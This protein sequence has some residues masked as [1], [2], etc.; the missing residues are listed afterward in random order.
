MKRVLVFGSVLLAAV[1]GLLTE[2]PA[3]TITSSL[4]NTAS[5]FSDGN[6]PA[7]FLVGGAQ[8]GQPA[9]FNQSYGNDE[10]GPNFSET[11][12]HSFGA[13]ADPILSASITIGIYEHDSAA[14]GSQLSL[15]SVDS[16]DL[17]AEL[18][19]MFEALG[20]GEDGEYNEY[21]LAL[22]G[23]AFAAL[24]DGSALVSLTL[25]GPGLVTP[26]FP[27]PGPNPPEERDNNGANI[28]FSSL[29][30]TTR[31]AGVIPEP[32]TLVIWSVLGAMGLVFARRRRKKT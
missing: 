28:I 23:T 17:T 9:P 18:D 3:A 13:I 14:S 8:A 31:D 7:A 4:G 22:P 26:L 19:A 11:W 6:K 15:F 20:D 10:L 16:T 25:D 12:T 29:S 21:S 24:A 2:A 27:L 5:G 30:I 32:S 1:L